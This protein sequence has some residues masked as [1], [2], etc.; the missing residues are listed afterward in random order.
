ML[1]LENGGY[2]HTHT[3]LEQ[4][5]L[6]CMD[7]WAG[8]IS[9][10]CQSCDRQLRYTVLILH[11]VIL[12]GSYK[13]SQPLFGAHYLMKSKLDNCLSWYILALPKHNLFWHPQAITFARAK[14]VDIRGG[15]LWSKM[16]YRYSAALNLC[17]SARAGC[18]WM[19]FN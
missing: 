10:I 4:R 6:G 2:T 1:V 7:T 16:N 13:R 3:C 9:S 19:Y 5:H 11:L 17:E 15:W 12:V 14:R 18:Q 8:I